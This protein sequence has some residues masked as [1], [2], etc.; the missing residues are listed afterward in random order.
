MAAE[1]AGKRKTKITKLD[2]DSAVDKLQKDR[3]STTLLS[4]S[5][6]LKL[7][8]LAI[9]RISYFLEESWHFTS[10]IYNQYRHI[11]SQDNKPLTYR[12]FSELLIEH[13]N[14]G[15]VTSHTGSRGRQDMEPSINF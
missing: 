6:H 2:I 9:A 8:A 4:A 14:M 10:I 15:L 1:T 13:E 7:A 3:A 5:Y 12:R 11:Q